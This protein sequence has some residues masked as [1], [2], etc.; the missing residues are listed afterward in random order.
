MGLDYSFELVAETRHAD[1]A[2]RAIAA[3]LA[4][5]DRARLLTCL[6]TPPST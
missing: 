6:P 3:R 4:P 5:D 2:L 1:R